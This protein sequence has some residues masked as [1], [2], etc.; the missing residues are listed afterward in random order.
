MAVSTSGVIIDALIVQ[1]LPWLPL[2]RMLRVARMFRLI[3]RA[4]G[5]NTLMQT[6]VFSIPALGNVGSVLFLFLFIFGV[7][8][9]NLF[10]NVKHGNYLDEHANFEDM[11]HALLTLFRMIT[12]ESWDGELGWLGGGS[13]K[14]GAG[15]WGAWAEVGC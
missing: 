3:P 13:G 4:K 9:M 15:V 7:V 6:L 11:G 2:L 8:G 14:W 1:D 12:G 10:G 5:L